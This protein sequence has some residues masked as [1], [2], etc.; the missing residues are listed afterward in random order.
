MRVE[1]GTWS[2]VASIKMSDYRVL[3]VDKFNA[4]SHYIG[5]MGVGQGRKN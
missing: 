5:I 4:I 2:V 3:D 1:D